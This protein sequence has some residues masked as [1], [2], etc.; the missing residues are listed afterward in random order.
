MEECHAGDAPLPGQAVL[1]FAATGLVNMAHTWVLLSR[2][3][4]HAVLCDTVN[5]FYTESSLPT[6]IV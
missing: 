6:V 3:D 1:V 5:N 2:N 4:E